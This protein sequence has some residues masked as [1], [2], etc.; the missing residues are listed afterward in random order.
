MKTRFYRLP[1]G[2]FFK[3]RYLRDTMALMFL[4]GFIT[5]V[6]LGNLDRNRSPRVFLSP[7]DKVATEALAMESTQSAVVTPV[8]YIEAK[9][10]SYSVEDDIRH[11]FGKDAEDALKVFKCESGLKPSAFNGVNTN[12]SWD[13]GVAQINSVHGINKKFLLNSQINIRVAKVL[14]DEQGWTPW[15]CARKLGIK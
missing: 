11:V 10:V 6:V 8:G 2:K 9:N 3:K 4:T 15:V 5:L 13:A 12:G 1:N 14:F 7:L